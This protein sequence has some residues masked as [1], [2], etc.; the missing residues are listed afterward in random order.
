MPPAPST[1]STTYFPA[2]TSPA[3]T[4]A[5]DMVSRSQLVGR[6]ARPFNRFC[7]ASGLGGLLRRERRSHRAKRGQVERIALVVAVER[8][9]HRA[10]RE[11]FVAGDGFDDFRRLFP[12]RSRDAH[13]HV[14]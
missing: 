12:A 7:R 11:G 4:G 2:S 13:R 10:M 3:E 8:H 1:L 5:T 9:A 14:D 6:S